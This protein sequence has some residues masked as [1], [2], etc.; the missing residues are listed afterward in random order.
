[1]DTAQCQVPLLPAQQSIVAAAEAKL[2]KQMDR[3]DSRESSWNCQQRQDVQTRGRLSPSQNTASSSHFQH[4]YIHHW[5]Q[6][7]KTS[8]FQISE[9]HSSSFLFFFFF[10]SILTHPPLLKIRAQ[11]CLLRKSPFNSVAVLVAAPR[12]VF[13]F[14]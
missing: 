6:Q 2:S 9:L 13:F 12:V 7:T 14:L 4:V 10:P 3:N 5:V 8:C 1:M 11:E